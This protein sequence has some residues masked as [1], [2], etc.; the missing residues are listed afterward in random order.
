MSFSFF[1]KKKKQNLF[2]GLVDFHN[3][4]L[5]GIDDG[6]KSIEQSQ[7]MIKIYNDLGI[8]KVIASPHIFKDL[9]PN[10][11]K[12]IRKSYNSLK[13]SLIDQDILTFL[14]H[15]RSLPEKDQSST[16]KHPP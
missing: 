10:T 4:L 9:Y 8:E 11:P 6:S 2:K 1:F 12:T 5:P 15:Y 14:H 7:E 16:P 13:P 3:H